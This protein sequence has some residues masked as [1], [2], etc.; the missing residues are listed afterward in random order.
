LERAMGIEPTTLSLGIRTKSKRIKT[1]FHYSLSVHGLEVHSLSARVEISRL[2]GCLGN[3]SFKPGADGVTCVRGGN[4]GIEPSIDPIGRNSDENLYCRYSG[5]RDGNRATP[6]TPTFVRFPPSCVIKMLFA[7]KR[8]RRPCRAPW[9]SQ[10]SPPVLVGSSLFA[11][12]SCLRA[13]PASS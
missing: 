3:V 6:G 7:L 13:D 9:H 2:G 11:P 1:D 10:G 12:A 8:A 5:R 4:Q